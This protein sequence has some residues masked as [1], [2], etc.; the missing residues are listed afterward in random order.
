MFSN[1]TCSLSFRTYTYNRMFSITIWS[2]IILIIKNTWSCSSVFFF[3]LRRTPSSWTSFCNSA[4]LVA[5]ELVG[6]GGAFLLLV[7]HFR[8]KSSFSFRIL[9]SWTRNARFMASFCWQR[10]S[11]FSRSSLQRTNDI[12]ICRKFHTV[13]FD[14]SKT[15]SRVLHAQ[16]LEFSSS[17]I[18]CVRDR[19]R[20]SIPSGFSI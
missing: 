20:I 16:L 14:M 8:I 1:L 2:W 7:W 3:S 19:E 6:E 10:A 17:I 18:S 5:A 11:A 12:L 4:V 13:R 15:D 9:A